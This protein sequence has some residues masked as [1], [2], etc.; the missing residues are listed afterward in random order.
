IAA[1]TVTGAPRDGYTLLFYSG[2]MWTLP[3]LRSDVRYDPVRD[4]APISLVARAPMILVAHPSLP[5]KSVRELIAL[6]RARPVHLNAATGA[7]GAAPRLAPEL[8]RAMTGVDIVTI[9]YKSGA[10][11][12]A[13]LLSGE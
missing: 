10:G 9:P 12:M 2:T 4:F 5:V 7:S 1:Q 8:F 11:R 3:F 6:R 13:A